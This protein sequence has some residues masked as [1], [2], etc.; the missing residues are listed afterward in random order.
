MIDWQHAEEIEPVLATLH[1]SG[2]EIIA[3][4]QSVASTRLP[5]FVPSEKTALIVGR[6]VEGIEPELLE[7]VDRIVEIPMYGQKESFNVAAAAAMALYQ[8]TFAGATEK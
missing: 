1:A 4:E 8:L 6:E 7:H 2:Y 5:Q 3:L